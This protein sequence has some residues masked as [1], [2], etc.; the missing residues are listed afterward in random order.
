[1]L[2]KRTTVRQYG[3]HGQERTTRTHASAP[4]RQGELGLPKKR[5]LMEAAPT[6]ISEAYVT[7][8]PAAINHPLQPCIIFIIRASDW[9]NTA[10]V[11]SLLR[12]GDNGVD[13][14]NTRSER[15]GLQQLPHPLGS[16]SEHTTR[17]LVPRRHVAPV[18]LISPLAPFHGLDSGLR[19]RV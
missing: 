6:S 7:I 13:A 1:M 11:P 15:Y 18:A 14:L 4:E 16:C 5:Y 19:S 2:P 8:P 12:I 10:T 17:V 9:L 3:P